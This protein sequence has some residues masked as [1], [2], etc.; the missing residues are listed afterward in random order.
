MTRI[1]RLQKT[2]IRRLGSPKKGF[3]YRHATGAKVNAADLQRIENL[4]IPPAWVDVAISAKEKAKLQAVG[5]DAA[6]RWQY[7][8]HESHTRNQEQKKFRR[9]ISFTEALPKVRATVKRHMNQKGLGRERVM[10]AILR[11]LLTCFMRPGSDVY[12]SEN[13]SYGLTTLRPKHVKVKGDTVDFDFPGKSGVRQQRQLK[14][15]K[16]ARVVRALLKQ[17]GRDVFKFQN[18]N[19]EMVDVTARHINEY[20]K[21]VMGEKFSA[22]DFRTW[23]GTLVC[24]CALAR[25][26]IENVEKPTQRK[27]KVVAAIKETAEVLGNT[28]AV[29]RSSYISPVVINSFFHGQIIDNYF[30]SL[31][32]FISYNKKLHPAEISLLRFLKSRTNG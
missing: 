7:L 11:I 6:G 16:V 2:G 20:I 13:G 19:G 17:P 12:V 14:D 18:G 30:Q 1:E 21:E 29:C 24:A 15:P 31:E 8:Y 5:K 9:L 26:G 3:R 32:D 22:K 4:K 23:A 28:P 10:A 27:K 25:V